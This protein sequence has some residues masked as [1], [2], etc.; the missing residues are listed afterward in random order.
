[1]LSLGW[2][3]V[4]A[5]APVTIL[6]A[7]DIGSGASHTAAAYL[8]PR[9]GGGKLRALENASIAAWS[10]YAHALEAASELAVDYRRD[11]MVRIAYEEML[12]KSRRE[13]DQ[14]IEEGQRAEWVEGNALKELEPALSDE[15][16]AGIHMPGV[17]W[18]DGRK[19]CAALAVAI[20]NAGG[21]IITHTPVVGVAQS[22]GGGLELQT[23][24]G[25]ITAEKIVIACGMGSNDLAGM[26]SDIPKC[27][28]V[29]GVMLGLAMDPENPLINRL[30]KRPDGILCPRSDGR[31]LVGVTHEEGE[32]STVASPEAIARL[33]ASAARAVPGVKQ[34]KFLEAACGIRTFIGDGLLRLGRSGENEGVYY[35]LSHA[36][37]GFIRAPQIAK[38]LAQFI[39]SDDAECAYIS[40][41]LKR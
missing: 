16:K 35:S 13:F 23:P 25:L 14:R 22:A 19:L 10:D 33:M 12:E 15:V 38:E 8:E 37:A 41:F 32:T 18:V 7:H 17:H 11:G 29:K 6:E 1:G 24:K 28:P 40:P 39:Q 34:L 21:N 20:E 30:V 5:G 3:L 26:P 4:R 27:R 36:G 9:L 31:L 2:E